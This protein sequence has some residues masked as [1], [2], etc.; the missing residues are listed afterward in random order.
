MRS[1]SVP[2][3]VPVLL[4]SS[5]ALAAKSLNGDYRCDQTLRDDPNNRTGGVEERSHRRAIECVG[6][7]YTSYLLRRAPLILRGGLPLPLPHATQ[8]PRCHFHH[9][10]DHRQGSSLVLQKFHQRGPSARRGCACVPFPTT[11]HPE[12][13]LI[14]RGSQQA[15]LSYPRNHAQ[16]TPALQGSLLKQERVESHRGL[17][18]RHVQS[19]WMK[20]SG[21]ELDGVMPSV[22][23]FAVRP[24]NWSPRAGAWNAPES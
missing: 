18:R 5:P 19:H 17:P 15:Q 22:S 10:I 13:G 24:L 20:R 3:S 2:V 21:M 16:Q 23:P 8:L 4:L 9:F 12:I 7:L 11:L 6:C 14:S 1:I